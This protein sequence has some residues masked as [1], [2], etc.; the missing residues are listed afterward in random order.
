MPTLETVVADHTWRWREAQRLAREAYEEWRLRPGPATYAEYRA[1]QDF[2]DDA[3]D[4]LAWRVQ[5]RSRS[6]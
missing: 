6:T 2:A 1:A 3:Q 4:A 5:S